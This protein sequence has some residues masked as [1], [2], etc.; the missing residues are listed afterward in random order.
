MIW[1][2]AVSGATGNTM[3]TCSTPPTERPDIGYAMVFPSMT[4][5]RGVAVQVIGRWSPP[6]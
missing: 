1:S 5:V 6:A 4:I 3:L 2:G